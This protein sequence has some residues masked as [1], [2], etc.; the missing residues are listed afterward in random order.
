MSRSASRTVARAGSAG[1]W[2]ATG[3]TA[4]CANWPAS[5]SPGVPLAERFLL[6]DVHAD[7]P[8]ARRTIYVWLDADTVFGAFPLPGRDLWR[9]MAPAVDPG[10]GAGRMTDEDVLAEVARLL[11]ERTG[12][13]PSLLRDPGGSVT[14]PWSRWSPTM[15]PTA[16]S[17]WCVPTRISAGGD[18]RVP[19]LSTDG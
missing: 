9:L 14:T 11:G 4:A 13:D 5:D 7:L 12:C 8:L 3:R 16:R 19:A 1:W 18:V 6:V 10:S 15:V 17:C 2:G